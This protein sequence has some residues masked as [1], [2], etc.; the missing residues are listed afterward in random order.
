MARPK[1]I[2]H[3]S[4]VGKIGALL[5]CSFGT[6]FAPALEEIPHRRHGAPFRGVNGSLETSHVV[7]CTWL[8]PKSIRH[9]SGVGKTRAAAATTEEG[10][11]PPGN[12]VANSDLSVVA[13][14]PQLKRDRLAVGLMLE[15]DRAG[16]HPFVAP[17]GQRDDDRFQL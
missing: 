8:G 10:S 11:A 2:R 4:G 15:F 12:D 13:D 17:L 9:V 1:S 16:L 7:R 5:V 14:A 6:E 3:A